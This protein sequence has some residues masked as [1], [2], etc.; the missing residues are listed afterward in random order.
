LLRLLAVR[1]NAAME[2]EPTK[3]DPQKRKRRW[4]Q[5]SLRTL[6]IFTLIFDIGSA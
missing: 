2:A 4:I 3:T 5:F 1:D 6:L